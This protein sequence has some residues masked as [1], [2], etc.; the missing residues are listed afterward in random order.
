MTDRPI[1]D[2]I[3]SQAE[4]IAGAFLGFHEKEKDLFEEMASAIMARDE[5]AKERWQKWAAKRV[6]I[7]TKHWL[8]AAKAALAGDMRDLRLRVE[9]AEAP[10]MPVVLSE[11]KP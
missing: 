4:I 5:K 2:E 7:L 1:P 8:R 11:A 3:R 6:E 9:L 10:T